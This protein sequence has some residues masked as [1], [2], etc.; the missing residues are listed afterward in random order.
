[1]LNQINIMDIL[2]VAVEAGNEI[3]SVYH[4]DDFQVEHKE[5]SSPLTLADK[6]SHNTIIRGLAAL[7]VDIPVLSEEGK[8]ISYDER[9]GWEYLWVVDPLDGT[10]EFIKRNGEFTVNIALVHM[11]RP[12]L[13]V[14]YAPVLDVL[15]YAKADVGSFKLENAKEAITDATVLDKKSVKLPYKRQD[16]KMNVVASRS[17][18]SPETEEYVAKVRE[19]Y[20]DVEMDSAG[21]SLKLCLVAEGQAEVYPRFAPTMEWDTCA[22]HAIVE[23][24]GGT[25]RHP[26]SN[27]TL[28]Y[29]KSDLL[30]PWFIAKQKGFEV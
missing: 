18:M 10:K 29:N 11:G 20:G 17:H 28:R 12:V 25:V 1:M 27:E 19:K 3:L 4:S 8:S 2:R 30:N 7:D 6:K 22:G 26:E 21:S 9:K 24:S 23:Q 5:D 15:Y 14:I 13:G 16:G